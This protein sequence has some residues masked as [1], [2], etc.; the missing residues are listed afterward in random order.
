MSQ[1]DTSRRLNLVL[2][3]LKGCKPERATMILEC[4][5][6]EIDENPSCLEAP[7]EKPKKPSAAD[8]TL[9]IPFNGET[10]RSVPEMPS[11]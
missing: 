4:A 2:G 8:R 7:T 11:A 5:I 1:P 3:N 10:E 6:Q 9:Q